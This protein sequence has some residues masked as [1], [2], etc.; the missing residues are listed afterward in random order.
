MRFMDQKTTP[1][2]IWSTA[3]LLRQTK[4]ASD[5]FTV[6]NLWETSTF[7]EHYESAYGKPDVGH[8]AARHEYDKVIVQP[9]KTLAFAGLL[10]ERKSARKL[11]FVAREP[12]LLAELTESETA[13]FRFLRDYLLELLAQSDELQS[14]E[15]YR[16]SGHTESDYQR[17][18]QR[19]TEFVL[20]ETRINGRTEVRRIF[21]KVLNPLAAHWR[22][23]GSYRGHVAKYRQTQPDL[24][25]NQ[26]NARDLGRKAKHQ[27]RA[28]VSYAVE[29]S[30][31]SALERSH[32]AAVRE[33]GR[34][35][36]EVH[37]ALAAGAATHVH[38]I[39]PR[40][41]APELRATRE[42]LILLTASQHNTRAHPDN[43]TR[44]IDRA[45][46][47]ECL[48]AKADTIEQALAEHDNFYSVD[49]FAEVV[50]H[51]VGRELSAHTID[52]LRHAIIDH[53]ERL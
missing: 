15:R 53:R 7:A 36:S 43:V 2:I 30:S 20:R 6:Q 22:I 18:K 46:Q 48:L 49:A 1:D 21:P 9:L 38:H 5:W 29:T 51:V 52:E 19:F 4:I 39:V 42:N 31:V 35:S 16:D 25:Y 50:S 24:S 32:A 33:R 37:D 3:Y 40:S 14:F 28:T 27:P 17:L 34:R 45:Y 11:E 10:E 41:M 47:I 8:A 26:Q 44:A 12:E 23:P 13:A